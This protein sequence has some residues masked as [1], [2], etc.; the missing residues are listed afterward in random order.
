MPDEYYSLFN[1]TIHY[2]L[3]WN[4]NFNNKRTIDESDINYSNFNTNNF[5]WK[6]NVVKFNS[7]YVLGRQQSGLS[8][9][10]YELGE[11]WAG[12]R[13][14]KNGSYTENIPSTNYQNAGPNAFGKINIV[15]ANSS[16]ANLSNENHN[17]QVYVNNVL[18]H[19]TSYF[20]Y[21]SLHLD[22]EIPSNQISNTTAVKHAISS[23]GQGT[24]Y[25][26]VFISLWY[27][28]NFN[29]SSYD[30]IL[31][32]LSHIA[33]QKQRITITNM[34]NGSSNPR[35][36]FLDDINRT[37]PIITNGN[38]WEAV[39]PPPSSDSTVIFLFD[40]S[41]VE[42]INSLYPINQSGYFTDYQSLQ[43]DSAYLVVTHE[44][45]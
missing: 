5:C 26:H 42:I 1:D 10:K 13:H 27:P 31:F 30:E 41:D 15:S 2:Y 33:G 16:S 7:Q 19:D 25:Q 24:D 3:T 22:F 9:P 17:T 8:S 37:I 39:I 6:N 20:G 35:M 44:A 45:Y 23:I 29:F 18:F 32:G 14:Q 36:Y 34:I 28:H 12:P 43:I 38:N 4:N 40:S 21:A 11:G